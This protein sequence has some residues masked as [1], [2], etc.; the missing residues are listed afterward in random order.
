MLFLNAVFS[1]LIQLTL[2]ERHFKDQSQKEQNK[3]KTREVER[4]VGVGRGRGTWEGG[5][6]VPT[7][8]IIALINGD[9]S[10]SMLS[11]LVLEGS[12]EGKE[13]AGNGEPPWEEVG[14]E[15]RERY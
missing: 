12:G 14:M 4:E 10:D 1:Q 11:P 15:M 9:G 5:G 3:V 8:I 7:R 2:P 6:L 13:K